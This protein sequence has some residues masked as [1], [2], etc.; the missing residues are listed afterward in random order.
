MKRIKTILID[1]EQGNCENLEKLL[2]KYC[3][4]VE[5]LASVNNIAPAVE[6]IMSHKPD[7]IFLDIELTEGTG[8]DLLEMLPSK[9]FEVIFVT[10][11]DRYALK[12]IKFCALDYILKPV[13]ISEL[14]K[15]VVRFKERQAE[16]TE[17]RRMHL[18]LEN[19]SAPSKKMVLPLA[20]KMEFVD[21]SQ[22]SRC[23]GEGNYTHVHLKSGEKYLVC[24]ALKEFDE[25]LSEHNFLRVHQSHLVS[26]DEIK[27]Y[28]KTDGGYLK[29]KDGTSVSISRQRREMV[30]GRLKGV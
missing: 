4:Q 12:A 17:N 20:D 7:L 11:F 21:I 25:L 27:A 15:A 24:K 9:D 16:K 14:V 22:I 26:I 30:M 8:F 29:M 10:A 3:P 2:A 18:L 5:V 23:M 13:N 6:M 1:D 28:V 19:L